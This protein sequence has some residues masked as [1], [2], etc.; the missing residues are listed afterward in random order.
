MLLPHKLFT[1][2]RWAPVRPL[3]VPKYTTVLFFL[4]GGSFPRSLQ[5]GPWLPLGLYQTF[6]ESSIWNSNGP[7]AKSSSPPFLLPLLFSLV[8]IT[9]KTLL[10][11]LACFLSSHVHRDFCPFVPLLYP[12]HLDQCLEHRWYPSVNLEWINKRINECMRKW[13]GRRKLWKGMEM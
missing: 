8:C 2:F 1:A 13:S 10:F 11:Y 3:L 9:W 4:Q 5:V 6:S 7:H 12:E